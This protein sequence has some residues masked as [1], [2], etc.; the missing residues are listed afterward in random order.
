MIKVGH[1]RGSHLLQVSFEVRCVFVTRS[2]LLPISYPLL[3]Q[4]TEFG[5]VSALTFTGLH[6]VWINLKW[7]LMY[8]FSLVNKGGY[9][10]VRIAILFQ[11]LYNICSLPSKQ[12]AGKAASWVVLLWYEGEGHKLSMNIFLWL[13]LLVIFLC[14]GTI[15]KIKTFPQCTPYMYR[16]ICTDMYQGLKIFANSRIYIYIYIYR[17]VCMYVCF[18][19]GQEEGE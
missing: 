18:T 19:S 15:F 9:G 7:I 6:N 8:I 17:Y 5:V 3:M 14:P 16:A 13:Q 1:D 10:P 2:L 12:S 4:L 11:Q